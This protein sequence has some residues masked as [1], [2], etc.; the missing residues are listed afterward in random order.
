M[1][2]DI[3]MLVATHKKYSFPS[4]DVYMPLHVGKEGKEDLGYEG[5][6]TG[7]NISNKNTMYCEL[8]G[9]YW[10]YKNISCN[11]IGL[12]HYRRYFL[13]ENGKDYEDILTRKD[14]EKLM[15]KYDIVLP[16]KTK[17]LQKNVREAYAHMHFGKDLDNLEDILKKKYPN[18]CDAFDKVMQSNE[19][20]LC[21]MFIMSK[22]NFDDYC[23]WLFDILF[24][25]E[26]ITDITGYSNYQKRIYGFLAERL[27]N[28]WIEYHKSLK[29]CYLTII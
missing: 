7:E 17:T 10:A 15:L 18:Y 23:Y 28:V 13:N 16:Q 14:I 26:K 27:F 25:L 5:D 19:I 24:E 20:S 22:K 1:D 4:D 21:N 6:N 9:M 3:V 8:T 12:V 2:K 29:K 11:Y